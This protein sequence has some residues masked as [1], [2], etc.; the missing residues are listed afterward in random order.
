M[1]NPKFRTYS[2]ENL[3]GGKTSKKRIKLRPIEEL[4]AAIEQERQR[5]EME[6][7]QK[8]QQ[9]LAELQYQEYLAALRHQEQLTQE[10]A[11]KQNAGFFRRLGDTAYDIGGHVLG[12]AVGQLEGIVDYVGGLT[13]IMS[14]DQ[15][16][17]NYAQDLVFDPV[18]RKSK[19]SYVYDMGQKGQQITRGVATG[20]GQM[21]PAIA[22]TYLTGGSSL[23]SMTTFG[24]GAAGSATQQALQE[25]A[26]KKDA[27]TYGT[28]SGLKEVAIEMLFSAGAN[29]FMNVPGVA[30]KLISK[31]PG[32][33]F[34]VV[35]GIVG[36]GLEEVAA[37]LVEPFLKK[38][39][40]K[41]SE[42]LEPYDFEEM[43]MSFIVGSLTA[44]VFEGAN[45]VIGKGANADVQE[46]LVEYD[47]I[48]KLNQAKYDD[49]ILTEQD[50]QESKTKQEELAAG[51]QRK[52]NRLSIPKQ[53]ELAGKY[54][55]HELF[56]GFNPMEAGSKIAAKEQDY[57]LGKQ[58]GN[59]VQDL[60]VGK[61]STKEGEEISIQANFPIHQADEVTQQRMANIAKHSQL[62]QEKYKNAPNVIYDS[63]LDQTTNGFYD[64]KTNTVR[65][66]PNLD[67]SYQR[68]FQHELTH[69]FEKSKGGNDYREFIVA[70]LK[71]QGKYD[72]EYQKIA[73]LY[74]SQM[75]GKTET[76]KALFVEQEMAGR[77]SENLFKD[78]ASIKRLVSQNRSLA[79]KIWD[80]IKD[81]IAKF[82]GESQ[83]IKT[84]K[85][86]ERLFAKALE[87]A[88]IETRTETTVAEIKEIT[89]LNPTKNEDI[90]F[91][92]EETSETKESAFKE[93]AKEALKEYANPDLIELIESKELPYIV[94][95]NRETVDIA[96][97]QINNTNLE[98]QI[99]EAIASLDKIRETSN[100]AEVLIAKSALLVQEANRL[101]LNAEAVELI[102]S[103][104]T[105]L[106]QL[107]KTTQA[108]SIIQRLSPEGKLL[109][110]QKLAGKFSQEL[111]T[112]KRDYTTSREFKIIKNERIEKWL[113]KDIQVIKRQNILKLEVASKPELQ[114]GIPKEQITKLGR[115]TPTSTNYIE[116]L[117]K[118]F[119][120]IVNNEKVA[121][122]L[123]NRYAEMNK[124][125]IEALKEQYEK[126]PVLIPLHLE[127]Q[128]AKAKTKPAVKQAALE[129]EKAL[130]QQ[131]TGSFW[132]KMTQWR[133]IL[134]LFNPKTWGRNY[135][136]NVV[137][138]Q[139]VDFK[140]FI[141]R[142][143]EPLIVKDQS[144]RTRTFKKP[145][146]SVL[147]Y[148]EEHSTNLFNEMDSKFQELKPDKRTFAWKA[149][150]FLRKST[151]WALE[152]G[153]Q[154]FV[155]TRYINEF[156][157]WATAKGYTAN[158]I[159]G[160]QKILEEGSEY[161]MRHAL[162]A[163]FK[164]SCRLIE[165]INQERAKSKL[166][167]FVISS[168]MPFTKTPINIA[169]RGLEYS[170]LSLIK[171]LRDIKKVRSG[172]I[173]VSQ[174]VNT[175]SKGLTGSA[176][177]FLGM[178]LARLNIINGGDDESKKMSG[179]EKAIGMQPFSVNILGKNF[180]L[181]WVEPAAI[182]FF[183]GVT[184][185]EELVAKDHADYWALIGSYANMLDPITE[186]SFLQ[187][188]NRAMSS[189]DE[190]K[191]GGFATAAAQSFLAQFFP[192]LG[193]Q[194]AKALDDT[195]RT[196]GATGKGYSK[197]VHQ[198]INYLKAKVPYFAAQLQPY[199][200]VWGKEEVKT[201]WQNRIMENF[202]YPFWVSENKKTPVDE[203]IL[204]LYTTYGNT[205]I[206]PGIPNSYYTK[207]GERIDMTEQEYTFYKKKVGQFSYTQLQAIFSSKYYQEQTDENREKII[208]KVYDYARKYAK[209]EREFWA[210]S[211]LGNQGHSLSLH[212]L[213]IDDISGIQTADGTTVY[214]SR[215][216]M[217]ASYIEAQRLTKS[218]KYILYSL[219]GYKLPTGAWDTVKNYVRSLDELDERQ[220]QEFWEYLIR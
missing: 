91:S 188:I 144:Q 199:I 36:E 90:R 204:R 57:K 43:G 110:L 131:K 9:A 100:Q 114:S 189:Y 169:R 25:G 5:Q 162:E 137:M 13:G 23:A 159:K 71:K 123:A 54:G 206:L 113:E 118:I 19:Y 15:I 187:G 164:D 172:E 156:A 61:I 171:S 87:S 207:N 52:L 184:L 8:E 11:E 151:Y 22:A 202:A 27:L 6:N 64:P 193:S 111:E 68:I 122:V 37:D 183:T 168:V 3:Y 67:N 45:V 31:V 186:M 132:D 179:Y 29:K 173:T 59:V 217:V 209:G 47:N 18:Q 35:S 12:G 65:I 140:N 107:G 94:S 96:K 106:T 7:Y 81:L 92:L 133:Y 143:I 198:S 211:A 2:I 160:N 220:K 112:R 17:Y 185:Y 141:S 72:S 105:T 128:L 46:I 51:L 130:N 83:E 153:D 154:N 190:N 203:E 194:I 125:G 124:K 177:M 191:I 213:S 21:L 20:V 127:E 175:L 145:S 158:D 109:T 174:Y 200:N 103:V 135:I 86:A 197:K 56:M 14:D 93:T 77:Y 212:L 215:K 66:N 149:L 73:E 50:I 62:I 219:A 16:A 95:K 4:Q 165:L 33:T 41:K 119:N 28:L 148:L 85:E 30:D 192:T 63:H 40:Y 163:T 70:D 167:D 34:Q 88:E 10:K 150:E 60:Q 134:M 136:G 120:E 166:G 129:V 181:D 99:N 210:Y 108:A 101:G 97:S 117:T 218:Q 152:T 58:I 216:Q 126:K 82:K 195:R 84:L 170:P 74:A 53:I 69:Y 142:T 205:E 121:E 208:K 38:W 39:T 78:E 76:E 24:L 49:G 32:K 55:S 116:N 89:N 138:K 44:A 98:E 79:Q 75:Q 178:L 201:S 146:E 176:I 180:T 1:N 161:A 26:A 157:E 196:T 115:L 48:N 102:S 155:K 182:P 42:P 139:I 147:L 214:N 104:A 80:F